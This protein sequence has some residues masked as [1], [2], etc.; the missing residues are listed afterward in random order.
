MKYTTQEASQTAFVKDFAS[1]VAVLDRCRLRHKMV[2]RSV[3][4]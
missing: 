1:D 4:F 2:L 3:N